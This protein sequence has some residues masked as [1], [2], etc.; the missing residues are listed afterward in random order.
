MDKAALFQ[1]IDVFASLDEASSER[2]VRDATVVHFESDTHIIK[3]GDRGAEMYVIVEGEVQVPI[4]DRQGQL[5]F[6]AQYGPNQFFGELALLMD[7]PRTADVFAVDDCTLLKIDKSTLEALMQAH[8]EV[9]RLLTNI[10]GKRLLNSESIEQVGKYKLLGELGQGGMSTVYEG[11]HSDLQRSVAVKMLSHELLYRPGFVERFRQEAR[12]IARLRHPNVVSV[13]D[14]EEAYATFFIIMEKLEGVTLH[15]TLAS[16]GPLSSN[17]C[18]HVLAELAKAL[19][20]THGHGVIHRDIKPLNITIDGRQVKLMDFGLAAIPS[21]P[22]QEA[23]SSTWGSYH[24]MSPEQIRHESFDGRADIY[25]LGILAFELLTGRPPFEGEVGN[26]L[27]RHLAD[28]LPS[29]RELVSDVSETLCS[30][31]ERATAKDPERR[32]RDC[33]EVLHHLAPPGTDARGLS[34]DQ[35]SFRQLTFIAPSDQGDALD[36]LVAHNREWVQA[37]PKIQLLEGTLEPS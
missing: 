26:V 10:L 23:T 14:F 5:K 36:A 28:P 25:A 32:F 17:D 30:F 21:G 1:Q 37:H 19:E 9:A 20:Y 8:P 29:L 18:T 33:A 16:N 3:K 35:C 31:V 22:P 11:F 15:E 34:V 2:L 24:Y 6:I 27:E 7:G 12:T 4:E 13:H